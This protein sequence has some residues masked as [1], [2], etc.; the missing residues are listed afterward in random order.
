MK[1]AV[2]T[3]QDHKKQSNTNDLSH[4]LTRV[5]T[6]MVAWAVALV[7]S[8]AM[9]LA[10]TGLE[11]IPIRPCTSLSNEQAQQTLQTWLQSPHVCNYLQLPR[12]LFMLRTSQA[13][14]TEHKR[15]LYPLKEG[16]IRQLKIPALPKHSRWQ[17][18]G[19]HL[20]RC[21]P[22]FQWLP[23]PPASAWR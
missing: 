6:S 21:T 1:Q 22:C 19:K 8:P 23:A 20:Q 9:P 11:V 17:L 4:S 16:L 5:H 2:P 14:H 10:M 12:P 18:N 13:S 7:A 15:F 3:F